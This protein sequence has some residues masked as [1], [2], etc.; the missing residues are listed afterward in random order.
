MEP[1]CSDDGYN[2]ENKDIDRIERWCDNFAGSFLMPLSDIRNNIKINDY[3]EKREYVKAAIELS[4]QTSVS[5]SAAVVRLRVCGLIP[6]NAC[7]EELKIWKDAAVKRKTSEISG[8][9]D[10]NSLKDVRIDS[11]LN[12]LRELG[13]A[14]VSL[15][16][17]NY[18]NGKITY[19]SYLDAI[20]CL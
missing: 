19:L 5:K 15:A 17:K 6:S 20:G 9:D 12:K 16:E 1:V 3:I 18:S 11:A 13:P 14:Y 7:S 4:R 8:V 10:S 2:S